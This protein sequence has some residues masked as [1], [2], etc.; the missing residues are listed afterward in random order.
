M[1]GAGIGGPAKLRAYDKLTGKVIAE[2]DLPVG[3]TG[4]HDLLGKRQ[5]TYRASHGR[6]R[7]WRRLGCLWS[8]GVPHTTRDLLDGAS[9]E[10][11]RH[12]RCS[13]SD[14]ATEPAPRRNQT[15]ARSTLRSRF[16]P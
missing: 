5:T 16:F 12:I 1:G 3:A 4:G 2:F 10:G 8:A 6:E 7:L 13:P 11:P 15:A 14:L 9:D